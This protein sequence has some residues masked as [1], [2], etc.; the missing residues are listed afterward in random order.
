[1]LTYG[2]ETNTLADRLFGGFLRHLRPVGLPEQ[3]HPADHAFHD[4]GEGI[5]IAEVGR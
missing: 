4:T 1:M 2:H 5:A 3:A